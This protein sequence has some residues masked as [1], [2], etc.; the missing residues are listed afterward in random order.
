MLKL[1]IS[2]LSKTKICVFTM[3]KKNNNGYLIPKEDTEFKS[4]LFG[5]I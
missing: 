4:F 2:N 1:L 5:F 3:C